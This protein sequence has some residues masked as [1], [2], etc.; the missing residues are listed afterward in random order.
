MKRKIVTVLLALSAATFP[1]FPVQAKVTYSA[2]HVPGMEVEQQTKT[3]RAMAEEEQQSEE[4]EIRKY[5]N[6]MVY[7]RNL[8]GSVQIHWNRMDGVDGYLVYRKKAGAKSYKKMTDIT[9][10]NILYWKDKKTE[11]GSRY[12][13][14][15]KG[16]IYDGEEGEATAASGDAKEAIV[17][18]DPVDA[19]STERTSEDT[20]QISWEKADSASGYEIQTAD[21]RFFL[22]ASS[23]T[24]SDPDTLQTSAGG[25][26]GKKNVYVRLR[27]LG[28]KGN[29]TSTSAW[30]YSDNVTTNQTVS[31]RYWKTK[32]GKR[33]EFKSAA[34]QKLNQYDTFQGACSDGTY[35]YAALYNRNVNKCK[36]IK[37]RKS[38]GK[39]LK[40]SAALSIHH[41]NDITYN[42]DT[43][44]I[45]VIHLTGYPA[46][47]TMINPDTLKITSSVNVEIPDA[48]YG[49]TESRLSGISGFS[50]IAYDAENHRYVLAVKG[51]K[52]LLVCDKDLTPMR[53]VKTPSNGY[54]NQNLECTGDFVLRSQSGKTNLISVY[55]WEGNHL[56]DLDT[57][58]SWEME[59]V[60]FQGSTLHAGY[61]ATG[62]TSKKVKV[63]KKTVTRKYLYRDNYLAEMLLDL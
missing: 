52:D 21:N 29:T 51:S 13:Y 30:T 58:K 10:D 49:A 48:L 63:N 5:N 22:N 54:T 41:A 50:G 53:L 14:K 57:G 43:G 4:P 35:T 39:I 45:A 38:D 46:R 27:V 42:A 61:Y 15:V 6:T 24:V 40:T 36:I 8:D 26:T 25:Y 56:A 34:N 44:R 12:Y 9:A 60:F 31:R 1:V 47:V 55:D 7:A 20:L 16:Y 19:L 32:K 37:I 11:S 3:L 17:S 62:Y 33:I 59:H 28:T 23:Q 18:M 2:D